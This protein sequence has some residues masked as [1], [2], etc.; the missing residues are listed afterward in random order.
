MLDETKVTGSQV[1][2]V[3][4]KA[5]VLSTRSDLYKSLRFFYKKEI[6]H[7]TMNEASVNFTF[8][9]NPYPL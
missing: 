5:Q 6:S 2:E 7:T 3:A 4:V 1:V 9:G 8:W